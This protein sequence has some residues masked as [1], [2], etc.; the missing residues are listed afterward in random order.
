MAEN[1]IN[2]KEFNPTKYPTLFLLIPYQF[3]TNVRPNYEGPTFSR[4]GPTF[5]RKGPTFSRKGPTFEK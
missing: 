4:K 5:S 2:N 3:S 1:K